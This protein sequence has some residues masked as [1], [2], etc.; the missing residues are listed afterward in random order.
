M[1]YLDGGTSLAA[2]ACAAP[3][4]GPRLA[5]RRP[6]GRAHGV[7]PT[8]PGRSASLMWPPACNWALI[9]PGEASVVA[10]ERCVTP[11][12]IVDAGRAAAATRRYRIGAGYGSAG[13]SRRPLRAVSPIDLAGGAGDGRGLRARRVRLSQR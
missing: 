3:T 9:P 11:V 7:W 13:L 5:S 6:A 1:R 2:A 8:R 10:E 12:D 4:S